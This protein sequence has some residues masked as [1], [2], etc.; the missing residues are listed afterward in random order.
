MSGHEKKVGRALLKRLGLWIFDGL[1]A[2]SDITKNKI[3][4]LLMCKR[5][6]HICLESYIS[7]ASLGPE[8]VRESCLAIDASTVV[9]FVYLHFAEHHDYLPC[10]DLARK[11]SYTIDQLFMM[12]IITSDHAF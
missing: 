1:S 10:R 11:I 5:C 6:G 9:G 12:Y 2:S 3:T 7:E 8:F 4:G